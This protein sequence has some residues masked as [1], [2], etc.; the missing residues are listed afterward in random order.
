[1]A[2]ERTLLSEKVPLINFIK[3]IVIHHQLHSYSP[4]VRGKN[5]ITNNRNKILTKCKK[6]Q[7]TWPTGFQ[8]VVPPSFD[9]KG[10]AEA[11]FTPLFYT[12]QETHCWR[13][14]GY[15]VSAAWGR[16][17]NGIHTWLQ[18]EGFVVPLTGLRQN[19]AT[20]KADICWPSISTVESALVSVSTFTCK[21]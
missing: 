2:L 17:E 1:M 9:L 8:P 14:C 21:A 13:V 18:G 6:R 20:Q 7:N 19:N 11:W 16:E 12:S 4:S 3:Q 5:K 15:E 10:S